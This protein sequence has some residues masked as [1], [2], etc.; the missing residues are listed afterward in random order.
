MV[1]RQRVM[2]DSGGPRA[3]C[4][5]RPETPAQKRTRGG[6]CGPPRGDALVSAER[7]QLPEAGQPPLPTGAQVRV[8]PPPAARVIVNTPAVSDLDFAVIV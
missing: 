8:I 7:Y 4:V 5:S 1:E 6:P 3:Q 2:R